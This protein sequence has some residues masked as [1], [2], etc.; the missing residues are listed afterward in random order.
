MLSKFTLRVS[1]A[2]SS[3]NSFAS[4]KHRADFELLMTVFYLQQVISQ[5]DLHFLILMTPTRRVQRQ[6]GRFTW[7]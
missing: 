2:S 3:K 4:K 1:L 5:G 7:S 6:A